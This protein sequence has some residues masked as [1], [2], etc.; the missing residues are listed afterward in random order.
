MTWSLYTTLTARNRAIEAL[1]AILMAIW[2]G[3]VLSYA[4]R[5]LQPLAW[6]GI[7]P[8]AQWRY[9]ATAV[10][11]CVLH[12]AG[13]QLAGPAP[14]PAIMRAVGMAGM[15]A[16]LAVLAW[17]GLGSSHAPTYGMAMLACV[18]GVHNALRDAHYAR[19][20]IRD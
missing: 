2:A 13:T 20:V 9:I 5:G 6:A 1:V 18:A 3:V 19:E 7:G 17:C 16:L 11:S 4:L 14:L 10:L 8:D 12:M 15:A